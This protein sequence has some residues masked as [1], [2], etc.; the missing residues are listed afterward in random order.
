[1]SFSVMPFTN[2][3]QPIFEVANSDPA[4]PALLAGEIVITYGELAVR[5]QALGKRF[6]TLGLVAGDKIG[7]LQYNTPGYVVAYFAALS[8]GL[9]VVPL[10]TRLTG[11]E[12]ETI[13][14]DAEARVL[15]AS[16][17][18][19]GPVA[20]FS[21]QIPVAWLLLDEPLPKID[22]EGL[23]TDKQDA[24]PAVWPFRMSVMRLEEEVSPLSGLPESAP[25]PAEPESKCVNSSHL[26]SKAWKS[27]G[28]D[29]AALIYTSGTTGRPKGVM[30]S[31]GNILADATANVMVIEALADDRFITISPLFHVFGQTNILVSAMLAGASV[32]LVPRFSPRRVLEAIDH[33]GVTFMAAVP[34]MYLMML[35]HLREKR[36]NLGS[37]RV[38]HSGAAPMAIETFHAVEAAFGA[39]VQEGYGLS[40]ASSIVCSNP[41]HGT[42]KPGSVGLPLFGIQVEIRDEED[43]VL[44][45]GEIGEL[46]VKGPI[47][48]Q[49]YYCQPELSAQAL[50][51][52]A[53]GDIW[54]KTRDMGYRDVEDYLYIV[55]RTDDLI[56]IGGVKIYPREIEEV[57]HRHPAVHAVAVTG[58][59]STLRHES[60]KAF[61]VLQPGKAC[62]RELLQEF[63]RPVLADFKIPQTFVFVDALPQGATG[64]I[65]RRELL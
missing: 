43:K 24:V 4:R 28:D 9:V 53:H 33:Y 34:T 45:P 63:C 38:C 59:P 13:L 58:I 65:L 7:L 23:P 60:I 30:L 17:D 48:M 52:D 37:L 19:I 49:G 36:F 55:A 44:P 6:I 57:L 12:L 56:N 50:H 54:L 26:V 41:L 31:H 29:L 64:K 21:E 2:L 47:V 14:T 18:F 8:L 46:Y 35:S 11:P 40:E 15:I 10:N 32:V 61:V 62:T 5:V 22:L 3:A 42:R 25:L 27:Q 16:P 20:Q 51:A 39:P 1:M